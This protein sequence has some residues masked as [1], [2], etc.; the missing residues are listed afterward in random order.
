MN[1]KVTLV[2]L[3]HGVIH[4]TLTVVTYTVEELMFV[5]A[6]AETMVIASYHK[7]WY[8]AEKSTGLHL[9]KVDVEV[10]VTE[11]PVPALTG[12]ALIAVELNDAGCAEKLEVVEAKVA[13]AFAAYC[14]P[15]KL[16]FPHGFL[17]GLLILPYK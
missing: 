12:I 10:G 3:I 6:Y 11:Y 9:V 15:G 16:D 17:C 14:Q 4:E 2:V 8:A 13:V 5:A 7:T 1:A